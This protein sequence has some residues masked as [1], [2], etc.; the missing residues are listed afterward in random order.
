MARIF[1]PGIIAQ[2]VRTTRSTSTPAAAASYNRFMMSL[3]VRWLVL[4]RMRPSLPLRVS[5]AINL[6]NSLR[7]LK[8]DT[9]RC[10]NFGRASVRLAGVYSK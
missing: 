10:L 6:Q 3:S 9:S 7:M 1:P 2:V 5:S 8:G 4:N